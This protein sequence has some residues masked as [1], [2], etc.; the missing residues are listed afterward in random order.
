MKDFNLFSLLERIGTRGWRGT[1]ESTRHLVGLLNRVL[2]I[3]TGGYAKGHCI[4]LYTL[5]KRIHSIYK[6]NGPVFTGKYL[7]QVSHCLQRAIACE[8]DDHYNLGVYV[9][10]TRG[11][12]PRIIPVIYRKKLTGENPDPTIV[13]I[14]LSVCTLYKLMVVLPANMKEYNLSS[15]NPAGMPYNSAIY[16]AQQALRERS[17]ELISRLV[18]KLSE[19]PLHL[20]FSTVPIMSAGPLSNLRLPT[21]T[22]WSLFGLEVIFKDITS[23]HTLAM[24]ASS[25]L[26]CL[27]FDDLYW[28]SQVWFTDC[29]HYPMSGVK[30]MSRRTQTDDMSP[31]EIYLRSF[32]RSIDAAFIEYMDPLLRM[33]RLCRKIEGAG[34]VRTFVIGN[35]FLQRML[36]P[37]HVFAMTVLSKMETDGTYDQHKP[38][39]RLAGYRELFSYDLKSATD[40]L[41]AEL[42]MN[43]LTSL[44]TKE[45]GE[46]WFRLMVTMDLFVPQ[47]EGVKKSVFVRFTRGQPLGFYSSWAVFALTHHALVAIAADKV[48]P[49]KSFQKYAI[50]GDDLVIADAKV[51]SQYSDLIQK[52]GGVIS[53]DKSLVSMKGCCEFAKRFIMW[54][55]LEK[56][57]DAS[58][59]SI[60]LVK[61]LD[62]YVNPA[63]YTELGAGLR[64]SFRLR[65]AGYR[66]YSHLADDKLPTRIWEGLSKRWRRQL[67]GLFSPSGP[68]ALPLALWLTFPHFWCMDCYTYGRLYYSLL[69]WYGRQDLDYET[70]YSPR[71]FLADEDQH[72]VE[73]F[74]ASFV[75]RHAEHVTWLARAS[76]GEF[77]LEELAKPK[78]PLLKLSR[79]T[80]RIILQKYGYSFKLWDLAQATRNISIGILGSEVGLERDIPSIRIF[81]VKYSWVLL[82]MELGD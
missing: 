7:K 77:T 52:S 47:P 10:L 54:N 42:S 61:L 29:T 76:M 28:Y 49:G 4:A 8:K 80:D 21:R 48:Y 2:L 6:A 56:R 45:I 59:V 71:L 53:Y 58:P 70:F 46:S 20:G 82:L 50:L 41:P 33:G 79:T 25:M 68:R 65:H 69:E 36:Y 24:D 40:L 55:H 66:V 64:A 39:H 44:F 12:I 27:P 67:V 78:N 38:L 19:I 74:Y 75:L 11:R 23:Y 60:P 17:F 18:P 62:R 3:V 22:F 35:S 15:I 37:M 51:A 5:S 13:R 16:K 9:S 34:K 32:D 63:V 14:V 81:C 72:L 30:R 31:L 57:V 26:R 73:P 43:L 1:L